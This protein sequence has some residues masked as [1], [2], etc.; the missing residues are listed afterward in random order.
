MFQLEKKVVLYRVG[1]GLYPESDFI[2]EVLSDSCV[3]VM[4]Y[5]GAMSQDFISSLLERDLVVISDVTHL[6]FDSE[7]MQYLS[8]NSH[9]LVSSLRKSGPFP[10]GGFISSKQHI[11]GKP[12]KGIREDFFALRTAGIMS[13]GFVA[14]DDFDDDENYLLLKKAERMLAASSPAAYGC[15]YLSKKILETVDV[16]VAAGKIK[17]NRLSLL[18][19]L[20][21]RLDLCDDESAVSPYFYVGFKRLV[22]RDF[23]REELARKKI[24]CPIHWDTTWSDSPSTLSD[25]IFSIPCDARY[26]EEDMGRVADIIVSC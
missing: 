20:K 26:G 14:R 9:Y 2:Q 1:S 5:F 8:D 10:D 23:V 12:V 16:G 19:R 18:G 21:G 7:K 22:D 24:Y 15:S 25:L 17:R 3:F 6:L 11:L 13:R 4:H